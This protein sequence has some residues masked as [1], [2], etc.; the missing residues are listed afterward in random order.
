MEMWGLRAVARILDPKNTP[1]IVAAC[2]IV[3]FVL[4]IGVA[5]H[6][7]FFAPGRPAPA[8]TLEVLITVEDDGTLAVSDSLFTAEGDKDSLMVRSLPHLKAAPLREYPLG[9]RTINAV[10]LDGTDYEPVT[11]TYY[12]HY[13][14]WP[15][16]KPEQVAT[17]NHQLETRY[18]VQN[19]IVSDGSERRFLLG[20]GHFGKHIKL[21]ALKVTLLLK[22]ST[23]SFDPALVLLKQ[24]KNAITQHTKSDKAELNSVTLAASNL[25][26]HVGSLYIVGNWVE[27]KGR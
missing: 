17:N 7:L 12:S 1:R 14:V 8:V 9:S 24:D 6:A 10:T 5:S 2:C 13:Y 26:E 23:K 21:D 20:L 15:K 27:S 3:Y 11:M 22:D 19:A 4:A 16:L 25:R 18:Q